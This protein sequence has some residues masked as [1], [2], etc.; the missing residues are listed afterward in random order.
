[1]SQI[2]ELFYFL[3]IVFFAAV[4]VNSSKYHWILIGILLIPIFWCFGNF[5]AMD[6]FPG[7]N[8][9][10]AIHA[11]M[12]Q[13]FIISE[14]DITLESIDLNVGFSKSTNLNGKLF[15]IVKFRSMRPDAEKDGAKWASKDDNR[16]TRI[17]HFI[18]KY[19]I[20]ELP[21]L[22]NIIKGDILC[23]VGCEKIYKNLDL[24]NTMLYDNFLQ[25]AYLA[26]FVGSILL[27]SREFLVCQGLFA[28]HFGKA[29]QA[30]SIN[31]CVGKLGNTI[32]QQQ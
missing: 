27:T 26:L 9:D 13:D 19:R 4:T 15:K 20:D 22:L 6:Q 1:M 18:R 10:H 2:L 14:K 28:I 30:Q 11:M 8:S 24:N 3:G 25:R 32:K 21:Q 16:V 31:R 12:T 17:G 23:L 7:Y 29:V 5:Y